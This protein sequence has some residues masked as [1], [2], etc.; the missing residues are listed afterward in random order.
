M[1]RICSYCNDV[2]GEKEPLD[3]KRESHG[4]CP[5]CYQIEMNKLNIGKMSKID[6]ILLVLFFVLIIVLLIVGF[7]L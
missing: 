1:L 2:F 4:I 3:D 7:I 5:K 6:L